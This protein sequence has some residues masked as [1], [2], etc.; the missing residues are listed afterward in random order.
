M[1]RA[2]RGRTVERRQPMEFALRSGCEHLGAASAISSSVDDCGMTQARVDQVIGGG[3]PGAADPLARLRRSS[4]SP[5]TE[6]LRSHDRSAPPS[7]SGT[8]SRPAPTPIRMPHTA[9]SDKLVDDVSV[10]FGVGV[11]RL[12]VDV[13]R[14]G[15]GG[16][17]RGGC[18]HLRFGCGR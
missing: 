13:G 18:L 17:G 11:G 6:V 15:I 14:G 12:V 5:A 3:G 4:A 2:E 10:A 1:R 16:L 7:R 8:T 9:A